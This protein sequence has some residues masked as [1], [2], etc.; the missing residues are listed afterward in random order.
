VTVH[1][2]PAQILANTELILRPDIC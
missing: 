1:T 2:T